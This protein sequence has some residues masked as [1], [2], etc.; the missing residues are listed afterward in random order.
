MLGVK[1][2]N[3]E[4][5]KALVV[6]ALTADMFTVDQSSFSAACF[7]FKSQLR[8]LESPTPSSLIEIVTA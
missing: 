2:P 4:V 7:Q 6:S 8:A 3:L 5:P 1:G